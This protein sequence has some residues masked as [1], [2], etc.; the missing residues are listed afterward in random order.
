MRFLRETSLVLLALSLVSAAIAQEGTQPETSRQLTTLQVQSR[1]VVIDVVVTDKQ[2]KPVHGLQA[3]DFRLT[4]AGRSQI[5]RHSEELRDDIQLTWLRAPE[6]VLPPNVFTNEVHNLSTGALNIVLLDKLNT[7]FEAQ[8]MLLYQMKDFIKG[9]KP[10]TRIAIFGLNEKLVMLQ[11]FTSDPAILQAAIGGK[12]AGSK[13]SHDHLERGRDESGLNMSDY[14]SPIDVVTFTGLRD[15]ESKVTTDEKK[16]QAWKTMRSL[17]QLGRYLSGMPGRKNL[18]WFSGAFPTFIA[19][20]SNSDI[21]GNTEGLHDPLS[22][23]INMEDDVQET[24]GILSR[25]QV[26]VYPVDVRGVTTDPTYTAQQATVSFKDRFDYYSNLSTQFASQTTSE[27][28]TM[29]QIAR[30]TGGEAYFNT[31]NLT[32]AVQKAIESGSNY[33]TLTY[34]PTKNDWHG[35]YRK[36]GIKLADR[37]FHYKLSYR[38]GYYATKS[39]THGSFEEGPRKG[40]NGK[41]SPLLAS[42]ERGAPNPTEIYFK[43]RVL[44]GKLGSER[45]EISSHGGQKAWRRYTLDYAID[46]STMKL[47]LS[48]G[49]HK[50]LIE[51]ICIVYDQDGK[52]I[53]TGSVSANLAMNPEQYQAAMKGGLQMRQEITAPANGD[54]FFRIAV[55]DRMSDR[56]GS[57]EVHS[58]LLKDPGETLPVVSHP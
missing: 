29:S 8:A 47:D 23:T 46:F 21:L 22:S 19:P 12:G 26:A 7:P 51:L 37:S 30:E 53:N 5:V 42:L 44:P 33:Y 40:A 28:M 24:I 18:I 16:M 36:I 45:V 55:H 31:N 34:I 50:G 20:A 17:N 6:P 4:E 49:T 58:A 27:H 48:Q 35:E 11:G 54:A 43:V 13:P 32:G 56:V 57:V 41:P 3:T 15:F 14:I 2:G 52:I 25:A 38:T 10:G 9:M 1:I 39:G